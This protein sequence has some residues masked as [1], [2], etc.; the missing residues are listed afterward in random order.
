MRI[1]MTGGSGFLGR[2]LV[3]LLA[4]RGH[5]VLAPR[6]R[7]CDLMDASAT[8][9][10]LARERPEIVLHSAAY[11]GGLGINLEEPAHLVYRNSIMSLNLIEAAAR[12]GTVRKVVAIGSACSYP[13]DL[14]GSMSEADFWKGRCHDSVMGY[15]NSK[16][17]VLAAQHTYHAQFGIEQLHLILTNLYGPH[18]VYREYRSHVVAALIK[19]VSEA[20]ERIVCWGDGT[21]VR[22]FMY[23]GDA[24]EG[25]ARA[26][27][28][29]H[30]LV[31]INIGT[32]IGTSIRELTMAVCEAAGF[33]GE[34]LWDHSKP[35][36]VGHKVLDVARMKRLLAWEPRH[37]LRDGLRITIDWYLAN[38]EAAD[39]RP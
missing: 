13:G 33:R 29:P 36:G 9:A 27:S 8:L 17:L 10:Y 11:Y 32:G 24:A 12:A 18:D 7:E 28:L 14:A 19:K 3:P 21:P 31:P 6:S 37:T 22:E 4:E 34:V 35:N 25:I 23:V 26:L 38:K 39:A 2:H 1:L 16:R 20:K 30:D 15:G 5:S